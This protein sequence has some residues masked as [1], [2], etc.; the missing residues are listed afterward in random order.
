MT[1]VKGLSF[2]IADLILVMAWAEAQAM[3]MIVRLDG[4]T[5]TED[6]EEVL[7]LHSVETGSCRWLIWRE[8]ESVV[9][10]P[11]TGR[12]RRHGSVVDAL[13]ALEALEPCKR[14]AA[15][16]IRATRWPSSCRDFGTTSDL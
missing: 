11:L 6:Y 15:T 13:E 1:A 16:E 4:G 8:A 14:V 12:S 9:V 2:R 3:R 10:R 5:S 7:A